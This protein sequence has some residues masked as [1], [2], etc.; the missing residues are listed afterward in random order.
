M[1]VGVSTNTV[2][3]L[4]QL[5]SDRDR[6]DASENILRLSLS[7]PQWAPYLVLCINIFR[8]PVSV[9]RGN[10]VVWPVLDPGSEGLL[11]AGDTVAFSWPVGTGIVSK[12][13]A[14]C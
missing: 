9:M 12:P 8:G 13:R 14:T 7:L 4:L 5:M 11:V 3:R 10:V 1:E 2:T 6:R